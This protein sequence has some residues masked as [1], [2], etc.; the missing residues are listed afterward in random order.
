V[1]RFARCV[2]S[3]TE[4]SWSPSEISSLLCVIRA[5]SHPVY[6]G[7]TDVRSELKGLVTNRNHYHLSPP[8]LAKILMRLPDGNISAARPSVPYNGLIRQHDSLLAW[9]LEITVHCLYPDDFVRHER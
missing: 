1:S 8:R 9:R 3:D 6:T 5:T 7:M 2:F 4:T